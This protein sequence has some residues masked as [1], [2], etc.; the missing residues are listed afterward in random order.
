[1]TAAQAVGDAR[2]DAP[3]GLARSAT[4]WA[5]LH[6][7]KLQPITHARSLLSDLALTRPFAVR[8]GAGRKPIEDRGHPVERSPLTLRQAECGRERVLGEIGE[9]RQC[10]AVWW[11]RRTSLPTTTARVASGRSSSPSLPE[12]IRERY[13]QLEIVEEPP[14]WM[15][16]HG[17]EKIRTIHISDSEDPFLAALRDET[18]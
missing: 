13:P 15:L 7:R 3:A 10:G 17:V 2:E 16:E 6:V 18:S 8:A 9:M 5:S 11:S 4:G 14:P 12:A 1:M